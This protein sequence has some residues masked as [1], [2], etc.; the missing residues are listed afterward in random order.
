MSAHSLCY[1]ILNLL[2]VRGAANR[3][4]TACL[5]GRFLKRHLTT[6]I[7]FG[8]GTFFVLALQVIQYEILVDGQT[9]LLSRHQSRRD[10]D[11][12]VSQGA[13]TQTATSR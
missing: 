3:C 2:N 11:R 4:P 9:A 5:G 10:R 13:K 1:E 8:D 12:G 7:C 6:L